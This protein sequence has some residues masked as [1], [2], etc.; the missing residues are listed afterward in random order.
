MGANL[1]GGT[2]KRYDQDGNLKSSVTYTK[3]D[4]ES[5]FGSSRVERNGTISYA[6]TLKNLVILTKIF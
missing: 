4:I 6:I 1:T 3:S 2:F 5:A